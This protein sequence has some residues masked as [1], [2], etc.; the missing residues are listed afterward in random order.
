MLALTAGVLRADLLTV[1][2]LH[3]QTLVLFLGAELHKGRVHVVQRRRREI[4]SAAPRLGFGSRTR[5]RRGRRRGAR[6][7]SWRTGRRHRWAVL[8]S[9]QRSLHRGCMR[10]DPVGHHGAIGSWDG[11]ACGTRGSS[12]RA[13][14]GAGVAI[15]RADA[16]R[17]R[18]GLGGLRRVGV[19]AQTGALEEMLLL[20][21]GILCTD[22]LAV[23]T[24]HGETLDAECPK[25]VSYVSDACCVVVD[26][27]YYEIQSRTLSSSLAR[28]S[29]NAACTSWST[30]R[31]MMSDASE[32]RGPREQEGRRISDAY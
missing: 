31:P 2:A 10:I 13:I 19:T 8:Q 5:R 32:N 21:R 16:I 24:L 23:D 11:R 3:R 7:S 6:G 27:K 12:R 1:D 18:R 15:R 20:S 25:R 9:L 29:T 17:G 14:G 30:V 26:L 4:G 28:N 22:L